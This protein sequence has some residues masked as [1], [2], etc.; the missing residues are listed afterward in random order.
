MTRLSNKTSSSNISQPGIGL[1]LDIAKVTVPFG[2]LQSKLSP[3]LDNNQ[4]QNCARVIKE[5]PVQ[6]VIATNTT[7]DR[8]NLKSRERIEEGGLSGKPLM[9]N[10]TEVVRFLFQELG[11]KVT[12]IGAGGVFSGADAYKKIRAGATAVQIY[13]ALIYEGPGLVKRIKQE[14]AELLKRDGIN[15]V[16]DVIGI[17]S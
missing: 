10:S 16:K 11:N 6:G 12:I 3:D 5:F 2:I 1:I 7:L 13:T 8:R 9:D 17:D 4:L 14:L 15:C